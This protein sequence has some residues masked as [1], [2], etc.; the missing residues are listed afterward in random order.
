[1]RS[2]LKGR[3][4]LSQ[5]TLQALGAA[6][7]Q[8]GTLVEVLPEFASGW[9]SMAESEMLL[10]HYGADG[11]ERLV[12]ECERHLELAL[13][14]DPDLAIAL[15]TRGAVR[16]FFRRD[17]PAATA[18]LERALALVPSYAMAMLSLANVCAVRGEFAEARAW[19]DQ[20][21]LVDPLDVGINM[22][23]GDHLI[24]R[25]DYAAAAVALRR[26]LDLAPG[27][28]ASRFRLAWALA[29]GGRHAEAQALIAELCTEGSGELQW[30]EYAAMLAGLRGD[31]Q[32]ALDHYQRV[33][34]ASHADRASPWSLARAA[35]AAGQRDAAVDW[36]EQ[37][38][39]RRSSSLPFL[40]VTPAF[41]A[42]H[43]FDRF[44]ALVDSLGLPTVTVTSG[45]EH[46]REQRRDAEE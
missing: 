3:Q 6:R 7:S 5:R 20:A 19:M 1:M 10:A 4:L 36:L 38:V 33:R 35:A 43:D 44:G 17:F 23:V 22:N 21:L 45:V 28:R 29:L 24:L 41:D 2:Y 14:L 46:P 8:F 27:H 12:E 40:R 16:F 32:A 9:A 31:R 11:A 13:N 26:A 42:L 34:E 37:A 25:R 18:D 30:H 15:S 39:L